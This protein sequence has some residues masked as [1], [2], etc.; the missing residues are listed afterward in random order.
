M[1]TC[2]SEQPLSGA[3]PR[4]HP[5]EPDLVP[6]PIP[7]GPSKQPV[8]GL[9]PLARIAQRY[10]VPRLVKSVYFYFRYRSLVSPQANVQLNGRIS[11]GRGTVV[12]P[13]AV[14]TNQTGS[15]TI[16]VDCAI[17]SFNHISTGDGDLV[18]GDHVRLGP[19]VTILGAERNVKRRDALIVD[20]GHSHTYTEVGNDVLIGAGAVILAGCSIGVGAVIG[21]GSVV[22]RDVPPYAIVAGAPARVIGERE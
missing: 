15:I 20:Q 12:K 17:S 14:I 2:S 1:P 18:I 4:A 13:Y 5:P 22:T 8:S 16:G 3:R 9:T 11:F 7:P 19:G 21:A 6:G 10:L